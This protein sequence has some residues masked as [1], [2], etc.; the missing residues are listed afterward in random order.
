MVE[1][2]RRLSPALHNSLRA[3]SQGKSGFSGHSYSALFAKGPDLLGE[4]QET[5][6]WELVGPMA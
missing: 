2:C 4:F 3:S 1:V 5:F 6:Y